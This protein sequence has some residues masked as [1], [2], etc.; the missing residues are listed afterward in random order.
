M[1]QPQS[2]AN[3]TAVTT[4]QH[5][6][7][8]PLGMIMLLSVLTYVVITIVKGTFAISSLLLLGTVILAIIPGMLARKYALTL[9]DRLIRT[10]ETLRYFM[11]TNKQIDP[12]ITVDQ[13][14]A[15]RFAS[16]KE[17][18][19]LVEKAA[20]ENLSKQDIKL[21]IQNWRADYHR[22]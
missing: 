2:A 12:R 1:K 10:E 6:V 21:A 18:V 11:L 13:F 16:D 3:H 7:W 15:L 4:L 22:V 19:A 8:L 20:N 14:I 5:F 17:F 9:Q